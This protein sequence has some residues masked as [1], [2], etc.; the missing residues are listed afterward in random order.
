MFVSV[1]GLAGGIAV[2]LTFVIRLATLWF[3]ALV[4]IFGLVI[5]R[6]IIGG[7]GSVSAVEATERER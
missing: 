5:V 7:E 2:A 4:G 6:Y 1:A 3:A